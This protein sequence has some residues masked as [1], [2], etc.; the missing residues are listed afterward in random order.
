MWTKTDAAMFQ[1]KEKS[2][3]QWDALVE[4]AWDNFWNAS[5]SDR[6]L[7]VVPDHPV[8]LEKLGDAFSDRFP[9]G[10]PYF[11][12]LEELAND[13][14]ATTPAPKRAQPVVVK[15]EPTEAEQ[16]AALVETARRMNDSHVTTTT[17]IRAWRRASTENE[18]AWQVLMSTPDEPIVAAPV[19]VSDQLQRFSHLLNE[20]ILQRGV[21]F[22]KANAG[23]VS[24]ISGTKTYNYP[25]ADFQR[26]MDEATTKGL[27]R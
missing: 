23:Y 21:S 11:Q 24:L 8:L 13:I 5:V 9:D 4:Q 3:A 7:E 16:F 19:E 18:K 10:I 26:L 22:M 2:G 25:V 6:L 1:M 14:I 15:A 20:N 12:R 17:E 27:I